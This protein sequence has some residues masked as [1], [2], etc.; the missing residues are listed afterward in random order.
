M[1]NFDYI[2]H[3]TTGKNIKLNSTLGV[4]ILQSY[5]TLSQTGSGMDLEPEKDEIIR[6]FKDGMR[7]MGRIFNDNISWLLEPLD[8]VFFEGDKVIVDLRDRDIMNLSQGYSNAVGTIINPENMHNRKVYDTYFPDI[9]PEQFESEDTYTF[10]Y[11]PSYGHAISEI[12]NLT[13]ERNDIFLNYVSEHER[14]NLYLQMV[15]GMDLD[16]IPKFNKSTSNPYDV[17]FRW[18]EAQPRSRRYLVEW[19]KIGVDGK[20]IISVLNVDSLL[21]LSQKHELEEYLTSL[22]ESGSESGSVS[23]S[24][25][26]SESGSESGS[27][28]GSGSESGSGSGSGSE[29]E[30][31]EEVA[32]ESRPFSIGASSDHEEK[33][34]SIMLQRISRAQ[35]N[36]ELTRMSPER[37]YEL[38]QQ[39]LRY[40]DD[41]Y[42]D[43]TGQAREWMDETY[44]ILIDLDDALDAG[45]TDSIRALIHNFALKLKEVTEVFETTEEDPP[46][47]NES[48]QYNINEIDSESL[49]ERYNQGI[50][51]PEETVDEFAHS[52]SEES[53]DDHSESESEESVDDDSESESEHEEV[54]SHRSMELR[55]RFIL[56]Q[57][58]M[59]GL[60]TM[61]D[62]N[63]YDQGYQNLMRMQEE[64]EFVPDSLGYRWIDDTYDIVQNIIYNSSLIDSPNRLQEANQFLRL[65]AEQMAFLMS[66]IN[67][68]SQSTSL[69]KIN[70]KIDEIGIQE[71]MRRINEDLIEEEE[72]DHDDEEDD[73]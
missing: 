32:R 52:V 55:L 31:E 56:H 58:K 3:P 57:F 25:S 64:S 61:E 8:L 39:E 66:F 71:L 6:E 65:F 17:S 37:F 13:H 28:S 9:K 36:L 69:T 41:T 35:Y 11:T 12:N 16:E 4:K 7:E 40:D 51:N 42:Y 29:S 73:Y 49:I 14:L 5:K 72:E 67:N 26:G 44:E 59:L 34:P 47:D 33:P 18:M 68:E 2:V 20:K 21:H 15:G 50:E 1:N 23:E 22:S 10:Q 60:T 43:L 30:E 48:I 27:G 53:V 38:A 19:D 62:D 63:L 54:H 45:H 46:V 24:G 70:D